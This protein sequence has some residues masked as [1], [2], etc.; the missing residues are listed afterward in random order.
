LLDYPEE[1]KAPSIKD[2]TRLEGQ[3][4]K[5]EKDLV[6]VNN[7][8]LNLKRRL[9][10]LSELRSII[11]KTDEFLTEA[12]ASGDS[13]SE[14]NKKMMRRMSVVDPNLMRRFSMQ[15]SHQSDSQQDIAI[16]LDPVVD[17]L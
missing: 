16:P 10:E 3:L 4:D 5:L 17:M 1:P 2:I 9:L 7:N 6:D 11:R 13:S 8:R 15:I 14:A 12:E